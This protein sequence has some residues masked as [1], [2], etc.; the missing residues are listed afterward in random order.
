MQAP[1][2]FNGQKAPFNLGFLIADLTAEI[3]AEWKIEE[4]VVKPIIIE[5]E[6]NSL[7][8]KQ[9]LRV[10]DLIVE[11]NKVDI[12]AAKDVLKNLKKGMNTLKIARSGAFSVLEIEVR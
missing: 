4:Q 11:V 1:K 7:A 10:G 2:K 6:R 5:T 8:S 12:K 3:R 9:G